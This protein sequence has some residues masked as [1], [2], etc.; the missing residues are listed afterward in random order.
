MSASGV[1]RPGDSPDEAAGARST[2]LR[3]MSFNVRGFSTPADGANRWSLRADRNVATVREHAPD[4][5]GVQELQPEALA[6]YRQQLPEY[7]MVLGPAAGNE[8]RPEYNAIL[9]S[10]DRL[11]V[12]DADG[13][14]LSETPDVP[15]SSWRSKVVRT[16]NRVT[17]GVRGTE[18]TFRHVNTHLDHWSSLARERSAHLVLRRLA[19]EDAP[20]TLVT[21]DFNCPPGSP[22]HRAFLEHG[23]RDTYL[24][25]GPSESRDDGTFHAFGGVRAALVRRFHRARY[26]R[27]PMRLDWILVGD[28]GGSWRVDEAAIVRDRDP[29]TGA[30]PS[31][32]DPVT[33]ALALG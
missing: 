18:R 11:E 20:P 17:F 15:S 21:G 12:L 4:L 13:F 10:P 6:T 22:P 3:V 9:F 33:A 1:T 31:D 2:R 16:A 19:S 27:R 25:R 7:G 26:G 5:L 24:A 32:H 23:Y 8:R 30:P 29:V 14:W 28:G